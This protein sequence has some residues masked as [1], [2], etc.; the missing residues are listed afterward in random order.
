MKSIIPNDDKYCY[1]CKKFG[2]KTRGT[3]CHHLVFGSANRRCSEEDGLKVQLCH[4]HHMALHQHGLY[5]DELQQL[6]EEVW[7]KHYNKTVEDWIK[8]YGKN[9]LP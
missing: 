7:L 3:D 8:R 4:Y 6:A 5:K 9:F 1:I 2:R